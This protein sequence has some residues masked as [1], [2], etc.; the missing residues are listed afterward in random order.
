[1]VAAHR[2]ASRLGRALSSGGKRRRCR[3]R[4]ERG[5]K[6]AAVRSG[7]LGPLRGGDQPRELGWARLRC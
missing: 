7:Q 4:G 5:G 6:A 1:M 2:L 3:R